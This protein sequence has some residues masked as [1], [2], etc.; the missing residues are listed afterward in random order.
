MTFSVEDKIEMRIWKIFMNQGENKN[1]FYQTMPFTHG[2]LA[3]QFP[4][5]NCM[6]GLLFDSEDRGCIFF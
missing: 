3:A 6:G 5:V 4:L 2:L 1:F